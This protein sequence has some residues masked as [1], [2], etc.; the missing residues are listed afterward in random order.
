LGSDGADNLVRILA[1]TV[2][3][4]GFAAVPGAM[5]ARGL[6]QG[7]RMIADLSGTA[8]NLAVTCG[9]AIAGFGAMS[10]VAGQVLG[11]AVVVIFLLVLTKM[12][13][14][15]GFDKIAFGEVVRVGGAV[16]LSSLLWVALQFVPQTV[17]GHLLGT[18][19]L[20]FFYLALNMAGWPASII[21]TTVDRVALAIFSN[22]RDAG[23]SVDKAAGEVLG[24]VSVVALPVCAFLG[25]LSPDVIEVV[26]GS[27]WSPAAGVLTGLSLLVAVRMLTDVVFQLLISIGANKSSVASQVIWLIA[28][29]PATFAAALWGNVA[30]VGIAVG[31]VAIFVA[32]PVH[33]W[34]LRG[35]GMRLSLLV[36]GLSYP[37][38]LTA[39]TI[40]VQFA[41]RWYARPALLA[42]VLAGL[43]TVAIVA[44]SFKQ[45]RARLARNF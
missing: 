28:L 12:L 35:A 13:P 14:R 18:T 21:S 31:L 39:G 33:A 24:L 25:V 1:I 15:P 26:Y 22:S 2:F 10:L 3:L 37:L 4:D 17:V 8:V 29:V 34:V 27:R 42:V 20:G 23:I 7:R 44:V 6:K 30:T 45:A 43:V 9:M 38:V 19:A 32:V 11:T 16:T 36:K 5:L 41:I 40:V